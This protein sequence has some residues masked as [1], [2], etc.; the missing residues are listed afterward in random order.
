MKKRSFFLCV[1]ALLTAHQFVKAQNA[2]A[3][4]P[5]AKPASVPTVTVYG[6]VRNDLNYDSR[7]NVFVREGQLDLYPK[8]I[9]LVNGKDYNAQPQLNILGILTRL[10]VKGNGPDAFKAKTSYVLEGDFF[11]QAD[12]NIGSLR[13]RHG[14]VKL[15]WEKSALTLGQTWYPFFIPECFP[16][17]VNFNTGIPIAPF[18]WAGQIKYTAKLSA[19]TSL[20]FTAYKPRE[21]AV[22]NVNPA[23]NT[24]AASMNAALPDLNAHFQY[25]SDKFLLGAQADLSVLN[26]YTKYTAANGAAINTERVTGLSF[27]AYTKIT[28]KK[29]SIKAQTVFGQNTMHWVMMGGYYGYKPTATSVETY[30]PAKT[31]AVWAD[32]YGNGKKVS[33]ALFIGYSQNNGADAGATAAYGRMVGVSGRGIKSLARVAPRVDIYSGKLKFGTEL[34]FTTAEYGTRSNNGKVS[35]PTDKVQNVRFTFSTVFSF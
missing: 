34:E 4:T 16:G 7:Q 5:A 10:G 26:P 21:F 17:V 28:A 19:A 1:A 9:D 30:K 18:G 20:S 6:F 14:Y 3:A 24:N 13:I 23:D 8:D 11:G 35:G 15:D 22:A 2:P 33:P 25:K 31:T 32:I 12:V 27:M 29:F